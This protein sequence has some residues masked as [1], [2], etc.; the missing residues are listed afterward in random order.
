MQ[1]TINQLYH[2]LYQRVRDV[3][4]VF[5]NFYGEDYVDLQP[6]SLE[7]DVKRIIKETLISDG[8][9]I[10][11]LTEE[12]DATKVYDIHLASIKSIKGR[13]LTS[14]SYIYVWWPM[15]KVTNEHNKSVY[16]RDLYAKITIQ[17]DG[18]I[19]LECHGFLL[20]RAT[21]TAKQYVSNYLHSHV[22][23]IPKVHPSEF[24]TPCLGTGPIKNTIDT[25]KFLASYDETTWMLF[26]QE[27][28]LYVTVESLT[29]IPYRKLENITGRRVM[30]SYTGYNLQNGCSISSFSQLY[31][32]SDLREFV[33]YYLKHGHLSL[34]YRRN[35][36][37]CGMPYHEYIVDVSNAFIDFYNKFLSTTTYAISKC[38]TYRLLN[39]A[40]LNNGTFYC[41]EDPVTR[42]SLPQNKLVLHFKG[43][44]I[45]LKV[46]KE[47][48]SPNSPI[49]L[50]NNAVAMYILKHILYTINFRYKNEHNDKR[51]EYRN[52]SLPQRTSATES[53]APTA[54]R[55]LYI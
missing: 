20:N 54:Q 39:K 44:P 33:K 9:K 32:Q 23:D 55:V 34:S 8:V 25:L 41:V 15:V 36:I 42:I 1:F 12:D 22:Q 2:S 51:S 48:E 35:N 16:I 10:D 6:S 7:K 43:K 47:E 29:G 31:P 52:P 3:Y 38:F 14:K 4:D 53:H 26:C 11:N 49:V 45:Y 40:V 24:Q 21:Y 27:L 18:K 30:M 19:P 5:L 17:M 50:L 13:L 46:L 37:I 28:S